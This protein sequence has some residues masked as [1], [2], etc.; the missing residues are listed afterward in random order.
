MANNLRTRGEK[1]F[2]VFNYIFMTLLCIICIYPLWYVLV[3]SLSDPVLL[4]MQRGILVWPLGEWSIRGYQLVMENPNIPLGF[5]NTLIYLGIGTFINMLITTMAAYGLS[6]KDCYW[7]GKIMKLIAFTMYFAGGLIPFYL[8]VKNMNLLDTYSG[9]ILPVMVNTWN[10]IVMRTA[11]AGIPD[12]LE[13]SARLDGAND[14]TILW[15]IFFPLAQAT[16][17]VIALF[18]AVGW[19]NNWFNPSIFLSSKSKYP[20]QLVLREILLKNDTSAM[21]Q[22]GSIGQSQQEQY[23]M[24]VKYC[25]II[26][27]TVPILIVYPFLQRYFVK[28]VMVGSIKG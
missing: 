25:T 8:M 21:T 6:R 17:A 26:V 2:A 4:Y 19:W 14:W 3:A 9:I 22:V 28:G 7:N 1:S 10:L 5:R 20:L 27:A 16:I 24:L 15:R 12:S 23:R 13:E 11:F 18:Y